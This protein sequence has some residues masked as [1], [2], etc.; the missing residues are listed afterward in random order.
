ML[1]NDSNLW[2]NYMKHVLFYEGDRDKDPDDTASKCVQPGQVHTVHGV[3]FCVFKSDAARLGIS[4]VTYE[5][6]LKINN[7]EAT[8]FLYDSY[9]RVNGAKY[10]DTIA[11]ALTEA[12]WMSFYPRAATHLKDALAEFGIIANT[13]AERQEGAKKL[14]E[15]LLFDEYVKQR[16]A[17]LNKLINSKTGKWKKYKNGWLARQKKF[18]DTFKPSPTGDEKKKYGSSF[19]TLA[20]IINNLFNR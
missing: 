6:F 3:T 12:A 20:D 1:Y 17:F 8:K 18:Y 9:K 13:E 4:P 16:T 7:A 19:T 2:E 11:L 10:P 5:R 15:R 14:N